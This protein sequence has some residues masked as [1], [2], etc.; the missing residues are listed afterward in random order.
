MAPKSVESAVRTYYETKIEIDLLQ[1]RL[2]EVK[3]VIEEYLER[4]S[5]QREEIGGH[6]V[7]LSEQTREVCDLPKAKEEL[8]RKLSPFLR[9]ITFAVLRVK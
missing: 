6:I 7:S 8:G 3:P 9:Q 4:K 2:K 1:D 5:I